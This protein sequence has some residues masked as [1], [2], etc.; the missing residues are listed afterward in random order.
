MQR[1][2][3][4]GAI[5]EIED[6]FTSEKEGVLSYMIVHVWKIVNELAPNDI[7]MEFKTHPRLGIKAV[8]PELHNHP[9]AQQ[10][11]IPELRN[12]YRPTTITHLE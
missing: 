4:L 1:T 9:R 12:L 11:V 3:L 8:I 2:R 5:E 10:A 7:K 6:P